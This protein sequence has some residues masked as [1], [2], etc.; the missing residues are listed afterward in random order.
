MSVAIGCPSRP[1]SPFLFT[2]EQLIPL[3]LPNAEAL[4]STGL[5][6]LSRGMIAAQTAISVI[7]HALAVF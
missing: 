3:Q 7:R 2:G 4:G 1:S 5:G 6:D